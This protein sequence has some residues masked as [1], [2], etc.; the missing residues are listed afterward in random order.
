M[1]NEGITW[2]SQNKVAKKFPKTHIKNEDYLSQMGNRVGEG[3]KK[4]SEIG[5]TLHLIN[6]KRRLLWKLTDRGL[7]FLELTIQIVLFY[8]WCMS[9][10]LCGNYSTPHF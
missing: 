8:S 5:Q 10:N 1:C 2:P 4:L 7:M 6:Q 9:M 3:S